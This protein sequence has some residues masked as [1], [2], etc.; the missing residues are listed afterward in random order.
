[1]N[2]GVQSILQNGPVNK[3]MSEATSVMVAL[4]LS[5]G[6]QDAYSYFLRDKVFANA[7]TG[8][9]VLMSVHLFEGDVKTGLRY[10]FPVLFFA[11]GVFAAQQIRTKCKEYQKLHWRQLIVALEILL[12]LLVGFVP[13]QSGVVNLIAN[14]LTSFCCAMQVQAFRKVNGHA[15]ASTMCIGNMRSGMEALSAYVTTGDHK[16]LR[17]F[18]Q[19][20]FVIFV[21]AIGAGLGG[22]L[23]AHV[24]Q[25]MIWIS[26]GLLLVA[27]LL[28]FIPSEEKMI[29]R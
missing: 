19:Y 9:I 27:F 12:L 1:M 24:G 4:T 7:Q 6:M 25:H 10:L 8:N 16:C 11:F 14:A 20:M 23:A 28:M 17:K 5:G 15:Y 26:C 22:V 3:Q 2:M 21:F 18:G 29:D 13:L